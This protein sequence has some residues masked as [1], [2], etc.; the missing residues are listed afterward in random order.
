[1]CEALERE[2]GNY[3]DILH[4]EREIKNLLLCQN[5]KLREENEMLRL[6]IEMLTDEDKVGDDNG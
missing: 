2:I 6:E 3:I 5:E 1:M 4:K